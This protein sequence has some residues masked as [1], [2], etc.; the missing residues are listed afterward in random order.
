MGHF[1]WKWR[2]DFLM[3]GEDQETREWS[4]EPWRTMDW[5]DV[6][7]KQNW[8]LMKGNSLLWSRET[9]LHWLRGSFLYYIFLTLIL[10]WLLWTDLIVCIRTPTPFI[11]WS[12]NPQ[13]DNIG[14]LGLEGLIRVKW[15]HKSGALIR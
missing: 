8:A 15:T 3:G 10:S 5:E 4:Q 13:C 6:P 1:L 7:R 11:C 9:W 2:K 14:K 12:F